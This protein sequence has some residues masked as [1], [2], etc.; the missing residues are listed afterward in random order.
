MRR[1]LLPLI[2]VL[3]ILALPV[4]AQESWFQCEEHNLFV[5]RLAAIPSQP[6]LSDGPGTKIL[7]TQNFS[8]FTKY[9]LDS[10]KLTIHFD[11]DPN[12]GDA[13]RSSGSIRVDVMVQSNGKSSVAEIR[14]LNDWRMDPRAELA[15]LLRARLVPADPSFPDPGS[16]AIRFE[17][18]ETGVPIFLIKFIGIAPVGGRG[19]VDSDN[20]MVLDL[21]Q[22]TMSMPAAL[23]C[24]KDD[25]AGQ[26]PG[27]GWANCHWDHVH[28]DYDCDTSEGEFWL[29]SGKKIRSNTGPLGVERIRFGKGQSSTV[30]RGRI[31]SQE[32][33]QY[34]FS[35]AKADQRLVLR[36]DSENKA[37]RF[38]L[39]ELGADPSREMSLTGEPGCDGD[40]DCARWDGDLPDPAEYVIRLSNGSKPASY[41]LRITIR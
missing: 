12:S 36:L 35:V 2:S 28:Q 39:W 23:G 24:I 34:V 13:P 3:V 21:R 11:P 1:R 6:P 18:P 26:G 33:K 16:P 19:D 25:F 15:I 14:D 10:V 29:I 7:A 30:V 17:Q 41:T 27:G 32:V 38:T 37:L 8:G 4:Q 20:A 22:R 31:A 5:D 9:G 40:K